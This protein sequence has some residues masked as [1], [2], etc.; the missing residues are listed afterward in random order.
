VPWC[1]WYRCSSL[2]LDTWIRLLGWMALGLLIYAVY[3]RRHSV[4][5]QQT[6]R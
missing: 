3:G 1:P 6:Q 4:V 2:P 5:G